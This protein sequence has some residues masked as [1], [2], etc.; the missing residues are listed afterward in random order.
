MLSWSSST[1]L[2]GTDPTTSGPSRVHG[3]GDWTLCFPQGTANS[4]CSSSLS[5]WLA[6]VSSGS[7][8]AEPRRPNVLNIDPAQALRIQGTVEELSCNFRAPA[9]PEGPK[10]SFGPE[11]L[12]QPS[13]FVRGPL[14]A[15]EVC[16]SNH[17][18][19]CLDMLDPSDHP[20][21]HQAVRDLVAL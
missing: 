2:D 1:A 4:R 20:G 13:P 9:G 21:K 3:H 6:D 5:P 14:R 11:G 16:M 18:Q 15:S 7:C 8:Q 17:Q 19:S 10:R 12:S